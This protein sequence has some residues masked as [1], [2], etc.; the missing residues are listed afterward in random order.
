MGIEHRV[1][2]AW[3][4]VS[5]ATKLDA[6]SIVLVVV[7]CGFFSEYF[8]EEVIGAIGWFARH[9]ESTLRLLGWSWG[10]GPW[11]GWTLLIA[12]RQHVSER[13]RR[14][15]AVGLLVWTATGCLHLS[16]RNESTREH[17][18]SVWA[19]GMPLGYGWIWGFAILFV[20]LYLMAV[21]AKLSNLGRVEPVKARVVIFSRGSLVVWVIL[22]AV[23]LGAALLVPRP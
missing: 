18:R 23:S 1:G 15:L 16:G 4:K 22:L 7:V 9:D 11:I 2:I 3:R 13:P 17:Y 14:E 10:A 5:T 19:D 8:I 21:V 6:A 20:F 12:F